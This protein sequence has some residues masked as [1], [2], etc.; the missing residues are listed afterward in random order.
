MLSTRTSNNEVTQPNNQT[1]KTQRIK[2]NILTITPAWEM[3]MSS[4][5]GLKPSLPST[6]SDGNGSLQRARFFVSVFFI[7]NPVAINE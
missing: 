7:E 6:P 5:N 2:N 4:V 3:G 1:T